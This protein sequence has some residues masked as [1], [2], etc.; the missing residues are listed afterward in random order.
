MAGVNGFLRLKALVPGRYQGERRLR[1]VAPCR[2]GGL[3][4]LVLDS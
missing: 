4:G 2:R 3:S 1:G